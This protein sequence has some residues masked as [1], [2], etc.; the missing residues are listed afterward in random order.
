MRKDVTI[1]VVLDKRRKNS[2]GKYPVRLRVFSPSPRTQKLYA[3]EFELT[4][5]EFEKTWNILKPRKAYKG[6]HDKFRA[7]IAKAKDIE[8]DLNPF[9]FK[10][11]EKLMFRGT[12][13]GEL[14]KYHY[15]EII[16]HFSSFNQF[17]SASNYHLSEKSI[18]EFLK[19]NSRESYDKLTFFDITPDWLKRYEHYMTNT[20]ARSITTVS[21]YLRALRAVFNLA[22]SEGDIDKVNYPFGKRKYQIPASKNIKKALSTDQLKKLFNSV[23]ASPEQQKAKDF[24]FFSYACSG[25]NVKDILMLKKQDIKDDRIEFYRA[26]T[27]QTSKGNLKP[28][29]VYLNDFAINVIKKYGTKSK[30]PDAFVFDILSEDLS[31][32]AA[33]A[34][35]K[36]F[37]RYINQ[38]L[39][40][41]CKANDLP[42]DC[43][44]QWARHSFATNAV[45]NGAS[46]EFVQESLGHGNMKT[47]Q[48][49]FAGFDSDAKKEFSKSLMEFK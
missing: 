39:K 15:K 42:E 45:R 34:K 7:L 32:E 14:I 13:E 26:K 38:H 37:T 16:R 22:I 3:T 6:M 43:S 18:V 5:E 17:G 21:M 36:N 30:K 31:A 44:P 11:F 28:I 4:P 40:K 49:Y 9:T 46:M 10:Q 12:G 35:V 24:W 8:K 47:T 33:H 2:L 20:K 48:N 19:N 29:V 1:S 25:M 41:L 27:I 23:P